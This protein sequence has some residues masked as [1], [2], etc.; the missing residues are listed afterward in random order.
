MV[1]AQTSIR[2]YFYL[3]VC[4]G[5][6]RIIPLEKMADP[7]ILCRETAILRVPRGNMH[8]RVLWLDT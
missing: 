7:N 4:V 6:N 2:I 3:A 5:E 1:A 8:L